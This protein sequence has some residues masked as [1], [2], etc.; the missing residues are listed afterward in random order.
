MHYVTGVA[1]VIR[2]AMSLALVARHL[3]AELALPF[4]GLLEARDRAGRFF[5]LADHIQTWR[6]PGLQEAADELLDQ[7]RAH[8]RNRLDDDVAVLLVELTLT[9]PDSRPAPAASGERAG[10]DGLC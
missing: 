6:Q 1:L 5:R 3:V 2:V 7:L 9:G 8:T 4:N 10:V